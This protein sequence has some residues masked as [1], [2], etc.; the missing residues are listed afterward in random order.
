VPITWGY[1]L[2][3]KFPSP[4]RGKQPKAPER[5]KTGS[6]QGTVEMIMH[7]KG[8]D[9]HTGIVYNGKQNGNIITH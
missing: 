5:I 8:K 2:T 9:V 3:F 7:E 1:H 4:S 6:S